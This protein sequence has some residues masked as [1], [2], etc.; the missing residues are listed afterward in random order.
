MARKKKEPEVTVDEM[1]EQE[2]PSSAEGC[3]ARFRG[4]A[5]RIDQIYKHIGKIDTQLDGYREE[6]LALQQKY[7]VR[8][9]QKMRR[10]LLNDARRLAKGTVESSL[11]ME[12]ALGRNL[13]A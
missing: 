9:R 8:N 3:V 11:Q 1:L 7:D 10:E 12:I 5:E 4:A 2:L 6:V 13:A